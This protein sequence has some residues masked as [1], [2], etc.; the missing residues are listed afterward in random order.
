MGSRVFRGLRFSAKVGDHEPPH[1][2]CFGSGFEVVFN[3]DEFNRTILIRERKGATSSD[4]RNASKVANQHFDS[5]IR[6]WKG[7]HR[8]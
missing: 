6:L 5:L 2:H 8:A 4:L 3:L 7:T 1:V